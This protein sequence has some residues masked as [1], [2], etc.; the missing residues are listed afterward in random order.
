[1]KTISG[2]LDVIDGQPIM[3]GFVVTCSDTAVF[4]IFVKNEVDL[5][6]VISCC[7]KC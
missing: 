7:C 4:G 2:F 1:M 3:Y 5:F 6:F